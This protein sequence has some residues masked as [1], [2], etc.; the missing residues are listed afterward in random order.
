M[1]SARVSLR[2]AAGALA[3]LALAATGLGADCSTTTPHEVAMVNLTQPPAGR[4]GFI[5]EEDRDLDT[6]RAVKLTRGVALAV[7]CWDSCD[8]VCTEPTL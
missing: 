2:R 8:Y 4:V 7:R 3:T 5:T 1:T 6:V